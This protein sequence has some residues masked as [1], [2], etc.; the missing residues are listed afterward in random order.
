VLQDDAGQIFEAHS[1]SAGLDYPGVGPEHSFYKDS[2]RAEYVP[3]TD[4]EA[5]DS[6]VYLSHS[7]GIIPAFESSHAIAELRR[8][9]PTL[10]PGTLVIVNLS[11]RGDKDVAEARELLEKRK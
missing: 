5:L 1:I 8:R 4:E 6:F 7:E 2:G 11:G 9:A 3:I 10:E